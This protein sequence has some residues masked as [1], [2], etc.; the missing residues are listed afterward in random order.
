MV[1]TAVVMVVGN[2]LLWLWVA[3]ALADTT[4]PQAGAYA[5]V[6]AGLLGGTVMLGR[7]LSLLSY[8]YSSA[9]GAPATLHR[10]A[11]EPWHPRQRHDPGQRVLTTVLLVT[12]TPVL[13]GAAVWFLFYA[14]SPLPN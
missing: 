6:A 13:V 7:V 11:A 9:V 14:G 12:I 4:A 5:L 3:S 2:P 1:A 8:T 10:R